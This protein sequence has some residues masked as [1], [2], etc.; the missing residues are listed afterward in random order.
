MLEPPDT[1]SFF[2]AVFWGETVF[3]S[4]KDQLA[5][6]V[7]TTDVPAYFARVDDAQVFK[8]TIGDSI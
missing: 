7:S 8:V 3:I 6:K 1:A 4:T 2:G 5:W